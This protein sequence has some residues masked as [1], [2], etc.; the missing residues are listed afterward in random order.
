MITSLFLEN[1]MPQCPHCHQEINQFR[2]PV[3][4]VDTII[5]VKKNQEDK[6]AGIVLIKRK[7]PPSGWA[8]PGGFLD[9]GETVEHCA[10]RESKEETGLDVN[11]VELLGIYSDPARDPRHHTITAVFVAD[12]TGIPIADD[13]AEDVGIFNRENLPEIIAFDHRKILDDYFRIYS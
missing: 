6:L 9:Y 7:N 10:I 8:I 13:D 12:A 2:N 1:N 4:T 11:L 3:P 5:R